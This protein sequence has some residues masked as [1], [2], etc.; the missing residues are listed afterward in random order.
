MNATYTARDKLVDLDE[1]VTHIKDGDWLAVGGGLSSREPMAAIRAIIR[2]GRKGLKV[3][4]SA[5]G[6]DIDM[7]CGGGCVATSAESY[8]GFEQ[9]FGLAPNFRRACESG[10]VEVAD[11][12]CYT[13]VQQLRAAAYGLPF[14]PVRSVRGTSFE[15]LH[16]EYVAMPCPY[17]GDP[18]LLVPALQ[19]DVAL[20][21]AQYG[22]AH[23]NLRIEGPPVADLLASRAAK[24]VV[25]TV[26]RIVS[27]A[28][29]RAL[30]GATIPYFYVAALAEVP[31]GAH[32][33]ACYP[34][35]AYD[36][37]HTAMYFAA[38]SAGAQAF[39]TQYLEPYVLDCAD[40]QDYLK[41]VGGT[42]TQSRLASW[43]QGD[44]AWM[45]LYGEESA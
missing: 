16:P 12:C 20:I 39:A 4:G 6:I 34:M 8:V 9:D 33:T 5:H 31:F 19:P 35:Y 41:R 15:G 27:N 30:G 14:L 23:G 43:S 26:E 37:P 22:D 1:L 42:A 3:V 10:A 24:K 21:H 2:A 17:T 18:L 40:H 29:L 25:A 11:S 28:E 13:V 44:A 32:P 36:R 45:Q 7:L 38:A